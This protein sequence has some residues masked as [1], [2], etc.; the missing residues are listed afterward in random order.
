MCRST[1][2]K[3]DEM[4]GHVEG[5]FRAKFDGE[6][7]E[8]FLSKHHGDNINMQEDRICILFYTKKYR[9]LVMFDL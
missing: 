8:G 3:R 4:R 6:S 9:L 2:I 7:A 5:G 1:K